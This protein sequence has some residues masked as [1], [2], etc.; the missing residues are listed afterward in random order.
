MP[1]SRSLRLGNEPCLS[2]PVCR[3]PFGL[4]GS[5]N[6]RRTRPVRR[7]LLDKNAGGGAIKIIVLSALER[8]HEG[9]QPGNTHQERDRDQEEETHVRAV[10]PPM[11]NAFATTR[12]E[13][14]DMAIAAMRGVTKPAIA[15][16]TATML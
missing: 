10:P 13:D 6:G 3:L 16:G 7:L 1:L 2:F 15:I 9:E 5:W 12:M 11:R 4:I 8:P 14:S